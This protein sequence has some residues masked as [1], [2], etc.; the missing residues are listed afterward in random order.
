MTIEAVLVITI[1]LISL[2][3]VVEAKL[4]IFTGVKNNRYDCK[5]G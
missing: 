2:T 3:T 5:I 1:I 4:T